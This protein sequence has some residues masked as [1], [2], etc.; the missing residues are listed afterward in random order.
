M[1][2]TDTTRA[3]YAEGMDAFIRGDFGKSETLFT[4]ILKENPDHK[5]ALVS[6]GA[7]R[8][9]DA[10]PDVAI[11]DFNRAIELDPSYARAFHLRGLAQESQD[12]H[13]AA[14]DDFGRALEIDPDYGAVYYSRASLFTKMGLDT[15]AAADMQMVAH[16]TQRNLTGYAHDHNMIRSEHLRVEDGLETELDR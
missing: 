11:A 16:M 6:R 15:D 9:K 4:H 1:T 2:S 10:R 3:H 13:P 14:I 7:A 8:L 12:N 5:L